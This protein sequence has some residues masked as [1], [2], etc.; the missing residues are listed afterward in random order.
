MIFMYVKNAVLRELKTVRLF[1]TGSCQT[2]ELKGE[3]KTNEQKL[4]PVIS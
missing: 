2:I 4:K 1:L 3:G